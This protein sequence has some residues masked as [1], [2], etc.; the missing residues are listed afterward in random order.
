LLEVLLEPAPPVRETVL[1]LV[2]L[3]QKSRLVPWGRLR[4]HA[5]AGLVGSALLAGAGV[6][7]V[8]VSV[9]APRRKCFRFQ[10]RLLAMVSARKVVG[11]DITPPFPH[12]K[13]TLPFKL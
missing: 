4:P 1:V 7:K 10:A 9:G 11:R 6:E 5:V 3:R 12:Q 2:V 13:I 8:G